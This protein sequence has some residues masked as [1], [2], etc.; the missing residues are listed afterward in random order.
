MRLFLPSSL[1]GE[2]APWKH[3]WSG[4]PMVYSVGSAGERGVEDSRDG[5]QI[6]IAVLL[7]RARFCADHGFVMID[8]LGDCCGIPS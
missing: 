1:S 5:E 4:V 2:D 3:A 7:R 6:D 8:N